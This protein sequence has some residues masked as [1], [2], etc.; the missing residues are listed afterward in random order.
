MFKRKFGAIWL[1]YIL[2]L[3]FLACRQVGKISTIQSTST[4]TMILPT[5]YASANS[6]NPGMTTRYLTLDGRQRSYILYIPP[7]YNPSQASAVVF[8]L[9]SGLG[10]AQGMLDITGFNDQPIDLGLSQSTLTILDCRKTVYS[11]G[12]MAD[13]AVMPRNKI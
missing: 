5:T 13:A 9:H 4:S 8:I 10:S 1:G 11:P 6:P 2:L 12:M 3:V 7:T